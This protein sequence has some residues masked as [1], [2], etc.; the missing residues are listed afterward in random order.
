MIAHSNEIKSL[1]GFQNLRQLRL[2][3][4]E[5]NQVSDDYVPKTLE[6][7]NSKFNQIAAYIKDINVHNPLTSIKS[8]SRF[9]KFGDLAFGEPCQVKPSLRVIKIC[10]SEFPCSSEPSYGTPTDDT[11]IKKSRQQD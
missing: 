9:E 7:L 11:Q 8:Y 3:D 10:P 1:R 5:N 6:V 4:V 2:L